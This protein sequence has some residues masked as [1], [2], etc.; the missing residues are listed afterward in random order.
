[1][2]DHGRRTGND[3]LSELLAAAAAPARE[4]EL[5]GERAAM[6]A[7]RDARLATAPQRRRPWMLK[8]ALA[9]VLTVK[10]AAVAAAAAGG[11]ALAA[12]TGTL[13][14]QPREEPVLPTSTNVV[15]T[16]PDTTK[17]K[18]STP[19]EKRDNGAAPSPSLKGLC[20][21]YTSGAG[22]EHGKAHENPA[23]SALIMAAGGADAV[24]AFCADLL[25]DKSG[26]SDNAPGKPSR[27]NR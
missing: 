19:D 21:A 13:P 18:P 4:H 20:Q 2:S 22:A 12:A 26:R 6:A 27:S 9:N 15:T 11:I 25:A 7:F 17:T 24:P 5:A 16:T 3:R 1:M 10:I 8:T 23:F 14:G